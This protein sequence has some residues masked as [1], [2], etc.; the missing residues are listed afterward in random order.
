MKLFKTKGKEEKERAERNKQLGLHPNAILISDMP[1]RRR[2][3]W[4]GP[5]INDPNHFPDPR[6]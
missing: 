3:M 2:V 1:L 6:D 5:D 4:H